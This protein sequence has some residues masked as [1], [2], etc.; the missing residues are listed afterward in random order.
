MYIQR[1]EWHPRDTEALPSGPYQERQ[2]C[3]GDDG[4]GRGEEGAGEPQQDR[5]GGDSHLQGRARRGG[6]GW[7]VAF[8]IYGMLRLFSI[9]IFFCII[10]CSRLFWI[11]EIFQV[12]VS[13]LALLTLYKL[14]IRHFNADF[15]IFLYF[16]QINEEKFNEIISIW[17]KDS[18]NLSSKWLMYR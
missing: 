13:R 3:H 17:Y 10:E 2:C 11:S 9:Q 5:A 15:I 12:S 14:Y 18:E 16:Y 7:Q 6:R 1:T 8:N 4:A